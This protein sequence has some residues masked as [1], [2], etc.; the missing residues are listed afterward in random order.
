M[1]PELSR[2]KRCKLR[3]KI[4]ILLVGLWWMGFSQITFK[5]LP[6]NTAL[7]QNK[8]QKLYLRMGL[9]NLNKV[10]QQVKQMPVL[11]TFLFAFF[12]YSMG[13]QTVMLAAT[14]FGSQVCN[15]Q[16]KN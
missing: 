5:H 12:F 3:S 10:W 14:L 9:K 7:P 4:I 13:V 6:K 11:K 15:C 1:F 8:N 16:Q 2:Y